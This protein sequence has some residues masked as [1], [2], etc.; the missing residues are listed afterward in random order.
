M[1]LEWRNSRCTLAGSEFTH[2]LL[3]TAF[4]S[5]WETV[6]TW[7]SQPMAHDYFL[8][9]LLYH[10]KVGIS[11]LRWYL[12]SAVR[13]WSNIWGCFSHWTG[14][15]TKTQAREDLPRVI[16]LVRESF[17]YIVEGISSSC[18]GLS[19]W[20][21]LQA[22]P[23]L[24]QVENQLLNQELSPPQAWLIGTFKLRQEWVMGGI[25]NAN[26]F[27]TSLICV[28]NK[29]PYEAPYTCGNFLVGDL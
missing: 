21:P 19:E 23:G 14:E 22:V 29:E 20:H 6:F 8:S 5:P 18:G 10:R 16:R 3:N 9:V 1:S 7:G 24:S 28:F 15:N 13:T 25:T 4:C 11:A 17:T 2:A 27:L 12:Q 26:A